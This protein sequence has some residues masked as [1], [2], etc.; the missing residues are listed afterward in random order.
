[1]RYLIFILNVYFICMFRSLSEPE[2]ETMFDAA[3][4]EARRVGQELKPGH[5]MQLRKRLR[6]VQ[7]NK[8]TLDLASSRSPSD[9]NVTS[10]SVADRISSR[11]DAGNY[12]HEGQPLTGND[13]LN[14]SAQVSPTVYN[15][16]NTGFVRGLRY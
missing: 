12:D 14:A 16:S 6:E 9:Q 7:F 13:A 1:M 8:P 4:T 15:S 2:W 3:T 11:G 5:R 10:G